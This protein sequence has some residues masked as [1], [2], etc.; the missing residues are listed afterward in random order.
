MTVHITDK[1]AHLRLDKLLALRYPACS[2]Q[3]FQYLIK[4]K[5]VLV[6]G[7]VA[8]KATKLEEGDE[9]EIEFAITPEITLEP[10]AIALDI[11]FEDDHLIA[12]N[13]PAGMV[14]HPAIGNWTGTF[15]NALLYHCKQLPQG[16]TLR[17]G[18][19]H[20]LDKETSGVLVAAK[21][22]RAQQLMVEKF[23]NRKIEK[24]Y[25]AI[26]IGNPGDRLIEGNIGRH[27]V[28]RKEMA[29][30][31]EGGRLARTQC[32]SI[33]HTSQLSLLRLFPETGR[34]HQLRVHLK[35]VGSPILGDTVYGNLPLNKKLGAKRQLLHAYRLHFTHPICEEAIE[36]KAPIPQDMRTF[37][38]Q[39]APSCAF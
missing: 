7:A 28:R 2:R 19:V 26:C 25:L 13:K 18:I 15:V 34:T 20:R 9:V 31:K 8:K 36:L 21:N 11:L 38:S 39:I 5:L 29:L 24:E 14:V 12:I 35:S 33:A 27:P 32:Q 30:L 22:E 37:I 1:E 3:Y 6:N 4:E 10:E 17:P 23:A 16:K